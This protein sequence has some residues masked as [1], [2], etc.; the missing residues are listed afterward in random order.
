MRRIDELDSL[1]GLAAVTV[2]LSHYFLIFPVFLS[3]EGNN[4]GV[5]LLKYSPLH[6]LWA[7]HEAVILFFILS[8]LVLTIPFINN[9][10][11]NYGEYVL[12]RIFR[13]Y[14]PYIVAVLVAIIART[15]FYSGPKQGLSE[16]F[17]GLWNHGFEYKLFFEHLF[18]IGSFNNVAYDPVLWSLIHE[19]RISL[20]FPLIV[21]VVKK[22]KWKKSICIAIVCSLIGIVLTKLL[23][24]RLNIDVDYFMTLHYTSMFIIGSILA[25]NLNK[26]LQ[27][28]F[29]I[30]FRFYLLLIGILIYTYRWWFFPKKVPLHVE[31]IGDWMIVF[32]VVSLICAL[33]TDPFSSIMK[34]RPLLFLGK[35]SYSLYLY[36]ALV[37]LILVHL[38]YNYLNI[39]V[40]LF[41]SIIG[42]L[43]V[44]SLAQYFIERNAMKIGKS[45]SLKK[46]KLKYFNHG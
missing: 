6:I 19:M 15:L 45:L 30:K 12:K 7:G 18:F 34:Y 11:T 27:N 41:I 32:G 39:Y 5:N 14:I 26:I 13:I 16:W 40:I 31:I 46:Y 28:K 43:L 42:S 17:N 21:Y 24:S 2:M 33:L 44:A 38:M 25:I 1:R 10:K 8:G 35:I 22:Y 23:N 4:I 29:I 3:A 37:M 9:E 20:V 36:H